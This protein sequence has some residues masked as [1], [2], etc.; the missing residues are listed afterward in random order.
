MKVNKVFDDVLAVLEEM[1]L[2]DKSMF[3]SR[4]GTEDEKIV[5]DIKTL[6][7]MELDYLS[8]VIVRKNVY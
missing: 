7:G 5:K 1:G 8:M 4:C 3:I 6:K 2:K